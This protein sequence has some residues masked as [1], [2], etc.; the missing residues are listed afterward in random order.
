MET[1]PTKRFTGKEILAFFGP[2][3]H[4]LSEM[5]CPE[6]VKKDID[7][8]TNCSFDQSIKMHTEDKN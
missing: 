6:K 4:M 3:M 8:S 2:Y 1:I 7:P 5:H